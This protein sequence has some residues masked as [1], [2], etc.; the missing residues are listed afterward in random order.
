LPPDAA[1][2]A[3]GETTIE[4]EPLAELFT[5]MLGDVA[6]AVSVPALVDFSLALNVDGPDDPAPGAS[7]PAPPPALSP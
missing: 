2:A 3:V 5:D 1:I 4:P 7:A 6:S